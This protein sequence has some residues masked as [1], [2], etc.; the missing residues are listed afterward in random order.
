M[1]ASAVIGAAVVANGTRQAVRIVGAS[2]SYNEYVSG[3][4]HWIEQ[5]VPKVQNPKFKPLPPLPAE[6]R[7]DVA[8][9]AS[10]RR[11]PYPDVIK[12]RPAELSPKATD[13]LQNGLIS[14]L[15]PGPA[16]TGRVDP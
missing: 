15:A 3:Y 10:L 14:N 13:P 7:D 9:V 16:F 5:N 12:G 2:E 4:L 8:W 6:F 1:N 11:G